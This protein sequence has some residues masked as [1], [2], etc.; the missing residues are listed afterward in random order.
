MVAI[1]MMSTKL[2]TLGLL[3][4]KFLWSRSYDVIIFVPD[5]INKVL[6]RDQCLVSLAFIER[7]YHNFN[8]IIII[9]KFSDRSFFI[10]AQYFGTDTR[11]RLE[12]LKKC[13]KSVETKVAGEKMVGTI[14]LLPLLLPPHMNSFNEIQ[15]F[16]KNCNTRTMLQ[17]MMWNGYATSSQLDIKT[18]NHVMRAPNVFKTLLKNQLTR[19]FF[20]N[21][22]LKFCDVISFPIRNSW[23]FR[24]TYFT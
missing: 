7:S 18:S 23:N 16:H 24:M 22:L 8:F 3:K 20:L 14:F 15:K 17:R 5:I 21:S 9:I 10:Q 12:I 2:A 4:I 1:L 6:S 19:H 13:G 11:Y